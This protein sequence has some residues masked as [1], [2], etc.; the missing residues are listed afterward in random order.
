MDSHLVAVEVRVVC[1]A[2]ERV[3]ADGLALDELRLEGLD[4]QAVQGRRAVQQDRVTFG[5]FLKDVPDLRRLLLDH[6]LRAAHGVDVAEFLEPADDERLE[7]HERHFLGQ[8]ALV[9]LEFR[10][11]DDDRAA[12]VID[13]L[14][15]QVLAETSA[16]ALEHVG[17]RLERTVA[18]PGDGATVAAVV[19][20]R[21]DGFLKHAL[22]VADDDVGRLELEQVL[23]P[24][25]TVDDAAVE[26]I[27]IAGRETSAFQRDERAQ[28]GRDDGQHFEDHPLGAGV[29]V[30]KAL[31]ELEALGELLA[32][33]LGARVPHRLFEFLLVLGEI[34]GGEELT[35]R[36]G[37][38]PSGEGLT[39]LL[40][41]FA[42]L[43]FGQE[44]TLGQRGLAGVN[45]EVVLIIDDA[46]KLAS[47]HVEHEA[48]A[49]RHALVE[50]DVRDRHG[51]FDVTHAF[52][53]HA[54]ERDF[55]AATV[56][57]DALVFDALVFSA[58]A[59]PVP[60]GTKDALAE[61]APLLGLEG[62]VVDRLGVFD[63]TARPGPDVFRCGDSNAD[64]V[65][66]DRAFFTHQF[67][68]CRFAHIAIL[69]VGRLRWL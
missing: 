31:R 8:T 53:A 40:D 21:I 50:P 49:R 60:G 64:L 65:K 22:F 3:N 57:D 52:A 15:E 43:H 17:Q 36:I 16:F 27:E 26:I 68:K 55:D 13:A 18:R 48:D 29:R 24:V 54:G 44:L 5:D 6:L 39:V 41:G 23:E 35:N 2:D 25:V 58:G 69:L 12:R 38:H 67:T 33:L 66:A 34:D 32:D 51:Q 46:L 1:G 11:D 4:R 19:E 56:A 10:P 42:V 30:G 62:P 63:L 61:K 37:T 47:A 28:V 45:D 9:Q 7:Q 14:A 59:L 20:E